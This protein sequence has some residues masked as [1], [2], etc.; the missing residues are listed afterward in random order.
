MTHEQIMRETL[1]VLTAAVFTHLSMGNANAMEPAIERLT[2][3]HLELKKLE[4][5]KS[6]T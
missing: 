3:A 1:L 6:T 5:S 2:N 4:D